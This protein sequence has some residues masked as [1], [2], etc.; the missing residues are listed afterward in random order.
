MVAAETVARGRFVG[1][2]FAG[3]PL[4]GE[5]TKGAISACESRTAT[6]KQLE[7]LRRGGIQGTRESA[8]RARAAKA[9]LRSA[10]ERLGEMGGCGTV[11]CLQRP[12]RDDDAPHLKAASGRDEDAKQVWSVGLD[13]RDARG[14][15]ITRRRRDATWCGGAKATLA[16]FPEKSQWPCWYRPGKGRSRRPT[17]RRQFRLTSR[18]KNAENHRSA[19]R[20][21]R[22]ILD[23][24][25][26]IA[27][28]C[29]SVASRRPRTPR[30]RRP[31]GAVLVEQEIERVVHQR[32]SRNRYLAVAREASGPDPVRERREE[33]HVETG[34]A[35]HRS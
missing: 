23:R 5:R 11:G 7:N 14:G 32:S 21:D 18:L 4:G 35:L 31:D 27:S 30:R 34:R 24:S 22:G 9:A 3:P 28:V 33:E 13:A 6:K 1:A 2:G 17:A 15:D 20:P 25:S 8:S 26:S 29:R 10:D 19:P 12:P 16:Y